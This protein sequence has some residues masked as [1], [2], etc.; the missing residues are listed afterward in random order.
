M[1]RLLFVD[2][3]REYVVDYVDKLSDKFAV[4]FCQTA[5]ETIQKIMESHP[6]DAV[7]LDN[8]MPA[9]EGLP[10]S[11]TNGGQDTGIY[12]LEKTKQRI[13]SHSTPVVILTNRNPSSVRS[14]VQKL[15]LSEDE[16]QILRKKDTPYDKLPELVHR[17]LPRYIRS[18]ATLLRHWDQN[19]VAVAVSDERVGWLE[20][21]IPTFALRGSFQVGDHLPVGLKVDPQGNVISYQ[22]SEDARFSPRSRESFGDRLTAEIPK[23]PATLD[24]TEAMSRYQRELAEW[25][26]SAGLR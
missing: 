4:D 3:E 22:I 26:R 13:L 6:Y 17:L 20:F 5:E 19:S 2:D 21:D 7:V 16:I 24:D 11:V 18:E 14:S 12:I 1:N 8:Q 9:P 25:T 23:A 15:G 10:P